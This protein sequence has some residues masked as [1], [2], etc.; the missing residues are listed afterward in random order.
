[1]RAEEARAHCRAARLGE[2]AARGLDQQGRVARP[3]VIVGTSGCSYQD[4]AY[5]ITDLDLV[6]GRVA[7]AAQ[8]DDAAAIDT[9]RRKRS[10]TPLPGAQCHR[11]PLPLSTE[12]VRGRHDQRVDR[13]REP[14]PSRKMSPMSCGSR[15][16]CYFEA[17]DS[18][19][20]T[21][22][23]PTSTSTIVAASA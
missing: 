10:T 17:A 6:E 11:C 23:A 12:L 7:Y 5:E 9:L 19:A 8:Q 4:P 16:A 3:S 20:T 2:H 21:A 22:K 1:M 15:F 13:N 14:A 18:T